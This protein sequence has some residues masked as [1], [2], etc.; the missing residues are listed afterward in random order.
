[1]EKRCG[2][3]RC[4][5][6]RVAQCASVWPRTKGWGGEVVV[7]DAPLASFSSDGKRRSLPPPPPPPPTPRPDL[8]APPLAG[9]PS[10]HNSSLAAE[11]IQLAAGV[12]DLRK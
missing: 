8:C 10:R 11:G 3:V 4:D 1:M 6:E 7:G 9:L 2:A 5:M 12:E